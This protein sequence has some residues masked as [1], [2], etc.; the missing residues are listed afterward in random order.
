MTWR[1]S[2]GLQLSSHPATNWLPL[3]WEPSSSNRARTETR[4]VITRYIQYPRQQA[5]TTRGVQGGRRG[6]DWPGWR[7]D[8]EQCSGLHPRRPG[9]CWRTSTHHLELHAVGGRDGCPRPA[10]G[11]HRSGKPSPREDLRRC[12][13]GAVATGAVRRSNSG[14]WIVLALGGEEASELSLA[15]R[16]GWLDLTARTWWAESLSA[17]MNE[18][19]LPPLV[20]AGITTGW[21]VLAQRWCLLGGTEGGRMSQ[22]LRALLDEGGED[23]DAWMRPRWPSRPRRC[24]E[25]SSK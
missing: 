12:R 9:A 10:R 6:V 23:L 5:L 25:S 8:V 14:E 18:S 19:L 24:E 17:E 16:T 13:P 11:R 1:S 4:K 2:V 22:R 3:G 20:T 21:H 15:S 7:N